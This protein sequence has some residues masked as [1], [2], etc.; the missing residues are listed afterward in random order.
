MKVGMETVVRHKGGSHTHTRLAGGGQ[1]GGR[2]GGR[3]EEFL[4]LFQKDMKSSSWR[5]NNVFLADREIYSGKLTCKNL[6]FT[7]VQP[8]ER[9]GEEGATQSSFSFSLLSMLHSSSFL[10]FLIF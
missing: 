1:A 2:A 4:F 5:V 7:T 9:T 8:K 3:Q 10:Y 6:S